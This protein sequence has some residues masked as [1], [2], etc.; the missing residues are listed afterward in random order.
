MDAKDLKLALNTNNTDFE[1]IG[2]KEVNIPIIMANNFSG[3]NNFDLFVLRRI[4]PGEYPIVLKVSQADFPENIFEYI[5][6][7]VPES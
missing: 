7:I 4:K 2:E 1:I 5:V 6:I 3:I